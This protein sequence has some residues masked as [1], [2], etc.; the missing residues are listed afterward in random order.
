[1]YKWS[2]IGI[3]VVLLTLAGASI[4]GAQLRMGP[5]I[6]HDSTV[7]ITAEAG[8]SI[9]FDIRILDDNLDTV[10]NWSQI[11]EN[12]RLSVRGSTAESDTSTHAWHYD[13][14]GFSWMKVAVNA[15]DLSADS[16]SVVGGVPVTHFTIPVTAF[17][18]G[19]ASL[20]FKQ[21]KAEAAI[22]LSVEPSYDFLTSE[23]PPVTIVPTEHAGYLVDLTSATPDSEAVY[24]FRRFEIV[25]VARDRYLNPITG[26]AIRT[27]FSA[28]FPGEF[29][30][31][32]PGLSD[33][34]RRDTILHGWTNFFLDARIA[35]PTQF[36]EEQQVIWAFSAT[37][38]NIRG[39]SRK[40][41]VLDHA[42]FEPTGMSTPDSS[43]L[44][45]TDSTA[46][47][48]F[49]WQ[50]PD[51]PDRYTNILISRFD[52]TDVGSD[53]VRYAIIVT[54]P[55]VVR[56]IV[57]VD[58]DDNG[59]T[60]SWTITQGEFARLVD[61]TGRV[62]GIRQMGVRWIVT[63]TD[64]LYTT[65]SS[66]NDPNQTHPPGFLLTVE[67]AFGTTSIGS[68]ST[69]AAFSLGRNYPNPFRPETSIPVEMNT[70]MSIRLR[71]FN[72]LGEEV[73]VLHDGF[74]PPGRHVFR[75]EG[76]GLPPGA[77][78]YRVE[79]EHGVLTRS[80]MLIR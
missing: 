65:F 39:E 22:V 21:S 16:V 69:V 52:S 79:S 8:S 23:S 54:D 72:L 64:G 43:T 56:Q 36:S 41:S 71:V 75:F 58:S 78:S 60:P 17:Q 49:T 6:I 24:L 15:V 59:L 50:M 4:C 74:A 80:M 12:V 18:N 34:F 9:T 14:Q 77:Y 37:N 66:E 30:V 55:L 32:K 1:M 45:L 10:R 2:A 63:A 27:A 44:V 31:N 73:A 35:R 47:V 46:L 38:P 70:G 48:K 13:P 42:P 67:K 53:T 3:A 26:H 20:T 33:I 28:R 25:V 19:G 40:Y 61:S 11:G 62:A 68:M 76:A 7:S 5:T 57:R 29:S 51:P